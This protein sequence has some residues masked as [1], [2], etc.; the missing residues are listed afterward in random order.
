MLFL[1]HPPGG[2]GVQVRNDGTEDGLLER[3]FRVRPEA[4]E[5]HAAAPHLR[6]KRARHGGWRGLTS[7][8][9][10]RRRRPPVFD[11]QVQ[12]LPTDRCRYE[13][14]SRTG[15]GGR[16]PRGREGGGMGMK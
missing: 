15:R 6:S 8:S 5:H 14:V 9:G 12:I 7:T 2:V 11:P 3:C 4:R 10:K 13:R 1:A 16:Y